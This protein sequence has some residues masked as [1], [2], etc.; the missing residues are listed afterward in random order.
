MIKAAASYQL[1]GYKTME[2]VVDSKSITNFDHYDP[3]PISILRSSN[4]VITE[5]ITHS[6][7]EEHPVRRTEERTHFRAREQLPTCVPMKNENEE[8]EE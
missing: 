2:L 1:I 5:E 4:S 8:E 6:R 3:H 7:A